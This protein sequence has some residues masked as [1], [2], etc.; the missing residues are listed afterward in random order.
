MYK[1][2]CSTKVLNY[3]QYHFIIIIIIEVVVCIKKS[4]VWYWKQDNMCQE[5]SCIFNWF[6]YM[7]QFIV[8]LITMKNCSGTHVWKQVLLKPT[9]L[10]CKWV[11]NKTGKWAKH[12]PVFLLRSYTVSFI[13]NNVF[14]LFPMERSFTQVMF[15]ILSPVK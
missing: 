15:H 13:I 2:A 3:I 14:V 6:W 5:N 12:H 9:G 10:T 8:A 1:N 7:F 11:G 4:I